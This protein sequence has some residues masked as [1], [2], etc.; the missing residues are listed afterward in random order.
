M[1][2][3][4]LSSLER[5][6]YIVSLF[7]FFDIHFVVRQGGKIL[8]TATSLF[9]FCY[10]K[11]WFVA[12]ITWSVCISKSQGILCIL[13]SWTDCGLR[14]FHDVIWSAFIFFHDF[15]FM[16]SCHVFYTRLLHLLISL[17]LVSSFPHITRTFYSVAYYGFSLLYIC[18][19]W[20]ACFFFY[21]D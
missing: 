15:L 17:S 11:V 13:L 2:D 16:Q 6:K 21:F 3:C 14:I 4:F 19:S 12:K 10:H 7:T 9:F 8:W 20:H 1:F 5:S 18:Y